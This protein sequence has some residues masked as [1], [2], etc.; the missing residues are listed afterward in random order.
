M[1]FGFL[2]LH[3]TIH[4]VLLHTDGHKVVIT[5]TLVCS[6]RIA[7]RRWVGLV[8]VGVARAISS[9]MGNPLRLVNIDITS[10]DPELSTELPLIYCHDNNDNITSAY[11]AREEEG[12]KKE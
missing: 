9:V 1:G 11:H 6:F 12:N 3:N 2:K 5:L 4:A 7:R 10:S 8:G